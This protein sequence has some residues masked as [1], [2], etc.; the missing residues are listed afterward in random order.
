MLGALPG[1]VQSGGYRSSILA[2]GTD[3]HAILHA[4]EFDYRAVAQ[5]WIR[6][7]TGGFKKR[8]AQ[9]IPWKKG[10]LPRPTPFSTRAAAVREHIVAASSLWSIE[11]T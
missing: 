3:R 6:T 11:A 4:R 9:A 5:R 1:Q 8:F 10:T 7:S 2:D